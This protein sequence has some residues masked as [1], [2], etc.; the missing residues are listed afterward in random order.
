MLLYHFQCIA[1]FAIAF[2]I[3][4]IAYFFIVE[5]GGRK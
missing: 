1:P 2:I 4:G 5:R 3:V